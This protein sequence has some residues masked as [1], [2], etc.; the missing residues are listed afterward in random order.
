MCYRFLSVLANDH[1]MYLYG[2]P[3]TTYRT[4]VVFPTG[5][6]ADQRLF[7]CDWSSTM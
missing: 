1:V 4:Y 7:L 2:S 3:H 5:I 6:A